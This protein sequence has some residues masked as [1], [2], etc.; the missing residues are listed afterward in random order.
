[1]IK[2]RFKNIFLSFKK[3]KTLLLASV[4]A[5]FIPFFVNANFVY[6]GMIKIVI[7][8]FKI[9]YYLTV[10]PAMWMADLLGFVMSSD[11]IIFSYTGV[12]NPAITA[13]LPITQGISNIILILVLL[14]VIV[15]IILEINEYG[16]KKMFVKLLVVALLI[17]FAPLLVGLIVDLSNVL[18]N[19]FVA[20]IGDEISSIKSIIAGDG[21][22]LILEEMDKEGPIGITEKL[23]VPVA[24]LITQAFVNI[25]MIF[26]LFLYVL[27]YICRYIAIWIIVIL[28]PIAFVCMIHPTTQKL[29]K[30][31]FKQLIQW[32]FVGATGA[33]FLYLTL[34]INSGITAAYS[35]TGIPIEGESFISDVFS[36]I[37]PLVM[38][39]IFAVMG[40][41][42][43]IKTSAIG[44]DKVI[45]FGQSTRKRALK[46]GAA[47]A[48]GAV[49]SN[50]VKG[51]RADFSEWNANRLQDRA[52]NENDPQKAEVFRR[53]SEIK[54]AK[55]ERIKEEIGIKEAGKIKKWGSKRQE[56][57]LLKQ[58]SQ[59]SSNRNPHRIRALEEATNMRKK[60]P[61][62][63]R[64]IEESLNPQR[65]QDLVAQ[66]GEDGATRELTVE[67]VRKINPKA[68]LENIDAKSL[69]NIDI[70]YGM[71]MRKVNEI[72]EKGSSEQ[73]DALRNLTD[74]NAG[75][76][77]T[78]INHL[79]RAGATNE[80]KREAD[81]IEDAW[82]EIQNSP[83]Y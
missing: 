34:K 26:V 5:L 32:S 67:S 76:I 17:N 23:L 52:D 3:T 49:R 79:R 72:G 14:V 60:K 40:Y 2:K 47:G 61:E 15:G 73:K 11:F 36:S 12:D 16:S 8:L 22:K 82:L 7:T 31:W 13:G 10:Y 9:P 19:Y 63:S 41:V 66:H 27:L 71:D 57:E 55:S 77:T 70:F 6:D 44:T 24:L 39:A 74:Q 65:V 50:L 64:R 30:D 28:S 51:A 38:V 56:E 80:E 35:G 20:G 46:W 43:A 25:V 4:F 58:L 83:N 42:L 1:M 78:R 62:L 45:N 68:F 21:G 53:N 48:V 54:R 33:F 37:L 29:W 18:M 69:N 75:D 81:G 59:P